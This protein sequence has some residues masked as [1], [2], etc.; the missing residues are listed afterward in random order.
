MSAQHRHFGIIPDGGR[1]WAKREGRSLVEAYSSSVARI[2]ELARM[3][4]QAGYHEV[5]VYCLS[6]ANLD[7]PAA[8]VDAVFD[9]M[10]ACLHQVE[11]FAAGDSNVDIRAIG[12]TERLPEDLQQR[13]AAMSRSSGGPALNLLV[14]YDSGLELQRAQQRAG[15]T[16]IDLSHFDLPTPLQVIF[17]SRGVPCS[18][19]SFPF[20]VN[21]LI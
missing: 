7:R 21:T 11:A 6:L 10:R 19:D 9:T 15:N 1:R 8:E 14:A 3:A 4:Y 13:F 18:A 12:E 5:S 16:P 17:R 20:K 2:L